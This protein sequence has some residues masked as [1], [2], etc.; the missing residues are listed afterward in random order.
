MRT[1]K[2]DLIAKIS[3][4]SWG[5]QGSTVV[6]ST[7]SGSVLVKVSLVSEFLVSLNG[8]ISAFKLKNSKTKFNRSS[9]VALLHGVRRSTTDIKIDAT[10]IENGHFDHTDIGDILDAEGCT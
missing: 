3:A 8:R 6:Q 4:S 10:S 7:S 2:V 1:K 9:H 5:E